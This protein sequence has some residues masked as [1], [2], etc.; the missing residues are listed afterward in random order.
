MGCWYT[1]KFE[2]HWAAQLRSGGTDMEGFWKVSSWGWST[3]LGVRDP[4]TG[5]LLLTVASGQWTNSPVT[6]WPESSGC[7]VLKGSCGV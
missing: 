1:L 5:P 4:F 6:A 3:V 2:N 7:A